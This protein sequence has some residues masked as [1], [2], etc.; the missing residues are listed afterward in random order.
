MLYAR[1]QALN[2]VI[3]VQVDVERCFGK[4][5]LYMLVYPCLENSKGL[6]DS[7]RRE[8]KVRNVNDLHSDADS[9]TPESVE[10]HE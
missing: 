6:S 9:L 2:Y 5:S 4:Q 1:A 7:G 10:I 8:M 3:I